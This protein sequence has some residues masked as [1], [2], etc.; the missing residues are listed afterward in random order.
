M[1]QNYIKYVHKVPVYLFSKYLLVTGP[2][3]LFIVSVPY[4]KEKWK[5]LRCV[6]VRKLKP[7]PAGSSK[8]ASKPYYLSKFMSFV[9]PYIKT[10]SVCDD[11]SGN[12]PS[13]TQP[14]NDDAQSTTDFPEPSNKLRKYTENE[15]TQ[16]VKKQKIK[17]YE[18]DKSTECLKARGME[19]TSTNEN[20]RKMFLLSLLPEISD[21]TEN[22]MKIFRRKV[23]QLIDD[24]SNV[25]CTSD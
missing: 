23:L 12:V 9:L 6:F 19:N 2:V 22:Q 18:P 20:P 8:K 13:P 4:C 17:L 10:N 16:P 7:S 1:T 21:M 11:V 14:E 15:Q 25:P 24:I 3:F 5:N